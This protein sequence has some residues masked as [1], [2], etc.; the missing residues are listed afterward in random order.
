MLLVPRDFGEGLSSNICQVRQREQKE[1]NMQRLK[2]IEVHLFT[3]AQEDCLQHKVS[4]A[5]LIALQPWL[6]GEMAYRSACVRF[7]ET[8]FPSR[9][10]SSLVRGKLALRE[11]RCVPLALMCVST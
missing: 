4:S 10:I 7:S 8:Y 6:L 3:R 1:V 2:K 5:V 11:F 9:A